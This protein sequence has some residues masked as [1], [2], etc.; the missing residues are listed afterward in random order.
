M[1]NMTLSIPPD[2]HSRMKRFSEI[3]WSEVVRKSIS[4][5]INILETMDRIAEK[6]KLTQKDVDDIAKKVNRAARLS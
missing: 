3:R 2:L 5:K 1:V 4:E 6:S